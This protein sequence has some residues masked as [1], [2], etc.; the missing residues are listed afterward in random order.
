MCARTVA[1]RGGS[2]LMLNRESERATAAHKAISDAA[3]PGATPTAPRRAPPA[4]TQAPSPQ[5]AAPPPCP[6]AGATI[7]HVPCDLTSF[8]SVRSAAAAVQAA[9]AAAGG[10]DVLCCNAGVMALADTATPDGCDVQMQTNHLSHFLLAK[11]LFPQLEA[12]AAAR[13][14]ARIVAHSSGARKW[15]MRPLDAAY[16]GRNGGRLGGDGASM[17]GGARWQRYHQTKLANAVFTHALAGRLAAR[18]SK[19]KALAAAPGLA[20]TNLQVTTAADGGMASTWIMRFAQS[21]E[22]GTLPLLHC[23]AGA[24]AASGELW[25]PAGITGPPARAK[26]AAMETDPEAAKALWAASEAS[27]GEAWAL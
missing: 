14:E 24:G 5:R 20:A 8:A 12:A 17:L 19:V 15:P 27:T 2:V 7:T 11:L 25:E 23:C 9:V 10:L 6:R 3:A 13:G 1:Q 22:D 26:P 16:L 21:A 18:G 4:P